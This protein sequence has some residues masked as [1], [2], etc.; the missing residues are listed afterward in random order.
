MKFF[1][2][3]VKPLVEDDNPSHI[4][5]LNRD[6]VL[7]DHNGRGNNWAWGY[8]SVASRLGA[9]PGSAGPAAGT[10]SRLMRDRLHK[11]VDVPAGSKFVRSAAGTA[12]MKRSLLDRTLDLLQRHVSYRFYV[13]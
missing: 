1:L 8:T 2:Q 10:S 5:F 12:A 13:K 11:Q 3:V 7:Y 4:P 9:A 6:S